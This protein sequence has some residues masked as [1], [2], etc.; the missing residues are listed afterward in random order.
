M[1]R[2][3]QRIIILV[4][5][6]ISL[7]VLGIFWWRSDIQRITDLDYQTQSELLKQFNDTRASYVL[8]ETKRI[9]VGTYMHLIDDYSIDNQ[10]YE[11]IGQS[12]QCWILSGHLHKLTLIRHPEL[13]IKES[14]TP[15]SLITIYAG[16]ITGGALPFLSIV[17]IFL[18]SLAGIFVKKESLPHI[19]AG[20]IDHKK[21]K[22]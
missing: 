11:I 8:A 7:V 19:F 6:V 18:M 4:L 16:H 12:R 22:K 21:R 15:P 13:N 2:P 1:K 14:A 5:S 9:F 17:F 10:K 20:E 3:N